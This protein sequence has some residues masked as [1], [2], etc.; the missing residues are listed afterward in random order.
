M[1]TNEALIE[2][3][4]VQAA[5]DRLTVEVPWRAAEGLQIFLRKH[6]LESTVC[7]DPQP[8][9]ARLEMWPGTDAAKLQE[10]LRSW[11]E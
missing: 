10:V 1:P 2:P 6:G 7:F 11:K 3:V 9:E 4:R 5:G 8:R